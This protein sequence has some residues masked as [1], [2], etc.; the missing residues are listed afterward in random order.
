MG[1]TKEPYRIVIGWQ[2]ETLHEIEE[3]PDGTIKEGKLYDDRSSDTP[4]YIVID[5]EYEEELEVFT[6]SN[7][8]GDPYEEA[9]KFI[10]KLMEKES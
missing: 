4:F 1:A 3:Q 6:E 7:C 5:N 9:K 10:K 8:E 2:S